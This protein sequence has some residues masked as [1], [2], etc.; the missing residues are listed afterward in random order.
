[1][2]YRGVDAEG[3]KMYTSTHA[4]E[5]IKLQ[6][7]RGAKLIVC[8]QPSKLTRMTKHFIKAACLPV[9]LKDLIRV[10][11]DLSGQLLHEGPSPGPFRDGLPGVIA[12]TALC[13]TVISPAA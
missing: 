2:S 5:K 1:M 12:F 11:L 7:S 3:R 10:G 8:L 6:T 4:F 13:I 9:L